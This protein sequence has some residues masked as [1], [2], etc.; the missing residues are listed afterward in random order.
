[1]SGQLKQYLWSDETQ[2]WNL[3]WARPSRQCEVYGI[4]GAFG[5]CNQN[6]TRLCSCMQGFK[7]RF[8]Q[9]RDLNDSTGGCKR[10][11]SLKCG[12]QAFYSLMCNMELPANFQSLEVENFEE[13]KSACSS[14]C[15]CKAY[16][17]ARDGCSLWDDDLL[18]VQQL[19]TGET[20]PANDTSKKNKGKEMMIIIIS[21]GTAMIVLGLIIYFVIWKRRRTKKEDLELPLVDLITVETAT[22]YFS[23][24]NK[25]GESGFGPVYK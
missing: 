15:S 21:V 25:V 23:H 6:S 7:E 4:W 8:P 11:T 14:T 24:E 13:Y 5:I 12:D 17:Y 10:K 22:N 1:M 20:G 16:A 2:E 18:N 3:F 19:S 9:D